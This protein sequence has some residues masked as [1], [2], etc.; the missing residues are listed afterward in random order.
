MISGAV[1]P[2]TCYASLRFR[3]IYWLRFV[4]PVAL[5]LA[6]LMV[7]FPAFSQTDEQTDF[8]ITLA[9][10]SLELDR[11]EQRIG[12]DVL[13]DA[14]A[15][16]ISVR[17]AW[18]TR[19]AEVA[20]DKARIVLE[21]RTE[22]LAALGPAPE[23][24]N[25]PE[26]IAKA[27]RGL[28]E[29]VAFAKSNMALAELTITRTGNL[30][31]ALADRRRSRLLEFVFSSS[32]LP[33]S[34]ETIKTAV[35]DFFHLL[36]EIAALPGTWWVSL[37]PEKRSP[38]VFVALFLML[39]IGIGVTWFLRR[40]VLS[41]IGPYATEIQ[42]AYSRRLLAAV[43]DGLA[44]GIVPAGVLI[45]IVARTQMESASIYGPFGDLIGT[46]AAYLVLFL[47]VTALPH[48]VLLPEFPGWRLT[49]IP[50]PRARDIMRHVYLIAALFCAGEFVFDLARHVPSIGAALTEPLRSVLT[51]GLN[52]A[53]GLVVLSLLRTRHWVL[54]PPDETQ[55]DALDDEGEQSLSK[56]EETDEEEDGVQRVDRNIFWHGLRVLLVCL[57]LAGMI[58]PALGYVSL[59]NY[60]LNNMLGSACVLALLYILRGLFREVIGLVTGSLILR[61]RLGMPYI[62]RRRI[63]LYLRFGVDLV[64][65]ILGIAVV[66]PRWG[67]PAEDLAAGLTIALGSFTVGSFEFSILEIGLAILSFFIVMGLTGASKRFLDERFL[68]E[69]QIDPGLR[70]SI[71]AGVGY[72]GFILAALIAVM[73]AGVD[74][75]NLALIA[76]ALSVGIGFGLQGIV[77]NFVSGVI[78][79][80]E[81]P[82][83][84]GDWVVVGEH[85]GFVKQ[86]N[87]RA[88]EIE[89]WQRASVIVPNADLL[90]FAV[91]NWTHKD[92]LGRV[93]VRV[94]VA[95]DSDPDHVE[96][97]LTEIGAA[98][99]RV[100]RFPQPAAYMF[101][102]A[103][104]RLVYE[105]RVFTS[106]ILWIFVIQNE[107]FK[108]I[109]RRFREEGITVPH[110]RQVVHWVEG[111][112]PTP[113][114]P[115]KEMLS[116]KS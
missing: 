40:L 76:G 23:N 59:G 44:K 102:I 6:C 51:F 67:V 35:P 41:R 82:I 111:D 98:H 85:E 115:P 70:H 109:L 46:S 45:A 36:G 58:A 25:E 21:N 105:L 24:G 12:D 27:R 47:L 16:A 4:M 64:M 89:T 94:S 95:Q 96:R 19:E 42:P 68:P 57:A 20:R 91:T 55:R 88:T 18:V 32:P 84:V 14:A 112:Q 80:I 3:P 15:Q 116:D 93:D 62:A 52:I 92:K 108:E 1:I 56:S 79:L 49:R 73:A 61:D 72:V 11:L 48:S 101:E 39:T 90:S 34:F 60:L 97:I 7:T 87:M 43:A 103:P 107:L 9:N 8:R 114:G 13:G 81:R 100:R 86:I 30:L 65:L 104:D 17:L 26:E 10:W 99:E 33:Y 83:K 66:A 29:A 110:S 2:G 54:D 77:N 5:L 37:P 113:T 71:T 74:L 50:A 38:M 106:D 22:Q 75:T 63:K 78:L 28:T 69:T 31:D 53:Q